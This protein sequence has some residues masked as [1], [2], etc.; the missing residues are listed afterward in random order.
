[1]AD[2]V[3]KIRIKLGKIE[4]EYEGEHAFLKDDLPTLLEN[5]LKL[6][7]DLGADDDD[8]EDNEEPEKKQTKKTAV[9]TV[10]AI[11][12]KLKVKN[13]PELIMAAAAQ[14]TFVE[15]KDKFSRQELLK[16]TQSATN[17][18]QKNHG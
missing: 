11:A 12:A 10:N 7:Q 1:M 3:S 16:A 18:Y 14:L 17:Y 15:Q 13:G 9:G 5:I 6:R 4:V 8:E 2:A